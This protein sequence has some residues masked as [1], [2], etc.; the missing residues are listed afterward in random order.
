MSKV[1]VSFRG[2]KAEFDLVEGL[3]GGTIKQSLIAN[4]ANNNDSELQPADIKLLFKGKNLEHDHQDLVKLLKPAGKKSYKIMAMG[5]SSNEVHAIQEE[6]EDAKERAPRIRD[7]LTPRG[8]RDAERRKLLGRQMI[9][10]AASRK[11]AT[12]TAYGFGRIETLPNLP[13]RDQAHKILS[14][15]ANDPGVLACMKKHN[16][17]VGALAELYPKGNV[18]QS[19]VCVMGLNKN[20]GQQILLRIRTDDLTGFRKI[21]S[22]RKVLYHELAHNVHS[23]HDG[24]F[25]QLMRQIETECTEMD[26]TQGEGLSAAEGGDADNAFSGGTYRLGGGGET[27]NGISDREMRAQAALSRMTAE[28]QEIQQ[29]CGCGREASFLPSSLLEPSST[30]DHST[31][32]NSDVKDMEMS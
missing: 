6:H 21:L 32:G 12:S 18:G 27:T 1:V 13:H 15:L 14:Q 16:W 22:I 7:D 20:K 26:W 23:E 24:K 9:M 31:D 19:A 2:Q 28:E 17:Q 3:T 10:A 25:F 30:S 5:R 11:T 29:N 4:A 8:Q